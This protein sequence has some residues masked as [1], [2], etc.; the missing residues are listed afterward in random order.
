MSRSITRAGLALAAWGL[1]L[2][3]FAYAQ[4]Y[5]S[6][7]GRFQVDQKRGCAPFTLTITDANL[8]TTGE[9]TGAKP[10]IMTKGDGSPGQQNQF[11]LT[12]TTAG[13]YTLQVLY[14]S[15]GPDDITII[16]DP[17]IQP[18]FDLYSCGGNRVEL[19][20]TDKNYQQYVID[21]NND[22]TPETILPSGN[23]PTASFTYGTPGAK[24]VSVRGRKLS[25]ADNCSA[26]V[27][28]FTALAVL[29]ATT[30][31][32]L[33]LPD[34]TSAT[35]NFNSAANVEYRLEI[36]TNSSSNFQ[37][38]QALYGVNTHTQTSL[39][40]DDNFYCFRI[41]TS[42]PC[43]NTIPVYSNTVCS[44]NFDMVPKDGFND[45]DWSAA[46]ATNYTVSRDGATLTTTT[47][48]AYNDINVVCQTDYCYTVVANYPGGVRSTSLQKCG[49]AF[50][51]AQPPPVVNVSAQRQI[52]GIDLTW[53]EYP[54]FIP[55]AY[56]VYRSSPGAPFALIAE[57]TGNTYT[58]LF[59][60]E[61]S[62]FC[63]R[64]DYT[65]VCGNFSP[66]GIAACP[67]ALLGELTP[68]NSIALS[69]N[70]FTGW[71]DGVARY[72]V[73]VHSSSGSLVR[74]VDNGTS[75]S[76]TDDVYDANN[77]TLNYTVR[78]EPANGAVVAVLSVSN[79]LTFTKNPKIFNANAFT[80]NGDGLNDRFGVDGQY[81]QSL[82]LRVFNRWGEMLFITDNR[83]TGWDGSYN[84]KSM[85]EGTYYFVADVIDLTGQSFK[86]SGTVVLLRK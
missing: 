50:R 65:D 73:D 1:L 6:R 74:T 85:P 22:G 19:I 72:L 42:D 18:T 58:D 77:Q 14:Q 16:V 10:C 36:G 34:A 5:T 80:P 17:N 23:A 13:T 84:G 45:L 71:E 81:I 29:P 25:A 11:T 9:C 12:Y 59:Y 26:L 56:R 46:G 49:R 48:T 47:S 33:T 70:A 75:T 41:G 15:I 78:A 57:A 30:I 32:S 86:Q 4:P 68:D 62:G 39:R 21:F 51:T 7:L 64:I 20:V 35:L 61:A 31:T 76:F 82:E 63:Y 67:I 8:I 38:G 54:A 79:S 43:A 53:I 2:S 60:T 69:W 66:E 52:G 40:V 44:L 28:S 24:S 37:A 27:K 83:D 3:S 55:P